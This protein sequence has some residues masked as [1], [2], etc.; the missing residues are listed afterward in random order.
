MSNAP[1]P[2]RWLAQDDDLPEGVRA[3]FARYADQGPN[4]QQR[5]RMFAH[6]MASVAERPAPVRRWRKLWLGLGLLT[7]GLAVWSA[8]RWLTSE[9][10]D[11][12]PAQPAADVA[13][14]AEPTRDAP[15]RALEATEDEPSESL[16]EPAAAS[17]SAGDAQA[18]EVAQPKAEDAAARPAWPRRRRN[19]GTLVP[20]SPPAQTPANELA[21]LTRARSLLATAADAALTLTDEHRAHFPRGTFVE[22]RELIAVEAL[23]RLGRTEE[24]LTRGKAFLARHA[25]SAHSERMRV[26][27]QSLTGE[28]APTR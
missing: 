18:R 16:I 24:A 27:L 1:D 17:A 11:R 19:E 26:I 7:A 10:F 14:P 6:V 22:E 23:A 20:P 5:A 25:R 8:R 4:D 9:G 21:L 28:A 2:V 3:G 13:R 15:E 12:A